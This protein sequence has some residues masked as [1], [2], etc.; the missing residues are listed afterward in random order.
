MNLFVQKQMYESCK[1]QRKQRGLT[2]CCLVRVWFWYLTSS[3]WRMGCFVH[4]RMARQD[5]CCIFWPALGCCAIQMLVEIC[6]ICV[7]CRSVELGLTTWW[8]IECARFCKILMQKWP[9]MRQIRLI[10][11]WC[12]KGHRTHAP[13]I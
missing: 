9:K 1:S 13:L 6:F 4:D 12:N 2:V 7:C 8:L 5:I 11:L 10:I 3:K